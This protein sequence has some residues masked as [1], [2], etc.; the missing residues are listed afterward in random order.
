MDANGQ[1]TA[2]VTRI[3]L[4]AF[5]DALK[6]AAKGYEEAAERISED[7]LSRSVPANDNAGTVYAPEDKFLFEEERI[8]RS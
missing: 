4:S 2:E 8:A 6:D 7:L 3:K 1:I 5:M